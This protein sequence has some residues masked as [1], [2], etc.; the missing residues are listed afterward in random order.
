MV[1]ISNIASD[2]R[3]GQ[4][5]QM[6]D[7]YFSGIDRKDYQQTLSV[8][9]PA[10]VDSSDPEQVTRFEQGLSTSQ[11]S[12]ITVAAIIPDPQAPSGV[13]VDVS[14]QSTQ[15]AGLGP[16]GQACTEWDVRYLLSGSPD[17]SFR[18]YRS[19]GDHAPC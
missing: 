16:D 13:S 7:A 5:G 6:L 8:V 9:D 2:P 12:N 11:D 17:T 3:A 19:H 4:I 14:F 15:D 1:D 10:L 18:L